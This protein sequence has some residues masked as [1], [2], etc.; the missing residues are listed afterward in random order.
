MSF[1]PVELPAD[2]GV[3]LRGECWHGEPDWL[4][5]MHD[6]GGDLEGW[7]PL[8]GVADLRGWSVL[9]LDLRGHGGSDDPWDADACVSDVVLA[10]AEARRRGARAVCIAG[11]GEG[12]IAALRSADAA[13]PD[14]LVLLSPGP[15]PEVNAASLRAPAV[16]KLIVY[17]SASAPD[18]A[19]AKR[20]ADLSIGPALRVGLPTA[21][22]GADLL[23]GPPARQA[24][25]HVVAFWDEQRYLAS[26]PAGVAVRRAPPGLDAVMRP[27]R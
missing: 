3:V 9:A 23:A 8:I 15:V 27:E 2:D 1:E 7:R 10:V 12:A 4:V 6:V 16:S 26:A 19:A 13:R 5:L 21:A 22:H 24:I 11:A 14:A 18:D 25:E 20:V 17:G